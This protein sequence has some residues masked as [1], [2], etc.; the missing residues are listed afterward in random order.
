MPKAKC[1]FFFKDWVQ[2]YGRTR[3]AEELGLSKSTCDK[4]AQGEVIP[5]VKQ[6]RIIKKLTNGHVDY[7]HI[8]DGLE[9][10]PPVQ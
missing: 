3:L 8:I 1:G 6:M 9:V 5:E 7:H 2:W 10:Q 4:W